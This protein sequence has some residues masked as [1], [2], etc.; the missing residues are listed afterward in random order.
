MPEVAVTITDSPQANSLVIAL[1]GELDL[2]TAPAC[3]DKLTDA[4]A[5]LSPGCRLVVLDMRQIDFCGSAG[6][7]M[8]TMFARAC[9]DRGVPVRVLAQ[10]RSVVR[11]ILELTQLD[12]VLPAFDDVM[13]ATAC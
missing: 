10:R 9:T 13:A 7:R 4:V 11:R 2:L 8:L 12:T 5:D 1:A 3:A 6:L